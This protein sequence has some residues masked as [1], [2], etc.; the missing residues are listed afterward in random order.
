MTTPATTDATSRLMSP[1]PLPTRA[2]A[3]VIIAVFAIVLMALFTYRALQSRE[4]AA[5]RVT[6]T[7]QILEGLQSLHSSL[8][9]AETG[10]RGFLLSNE[11]RYLEP[12]VAARAAV[13]SEFT[14]LRKL[15]FDSGAEQLQRLETLERISTTKLEELDQTI[16]LS[17]AGE[18]A[19]AIAIVRSDRGKNAMDQ[20]RSLIGEMKATEDGLLTARQQEWQ[21]GVTLSS[22]VTWGGS[23]LLLL[24]IAGAVALM[25]RDFRT[26]QI[27]N[28]LRT[29]HMGL[30]ERLQGEQRLEQLGEKVLDFLASYLGAQVGVA[31]FNDAGSFRRF[32]SYATAAEENPPAVLP[33]DGLL[34]QA[35][36]ERRVLHVTNVPEGYLTVTSQLGRATPTEILDRAGD[37]RSRR[38][39]SAGARILPP[40]VCCRPRAPRTRVRIAWCGRSLVARPDPA[41]G[42]ARRD[43]APGRGTADAAGGAPRQQRRA[44]GAEPRAARIPGSAGNA[45]GRARADQLA[46]RGA[47]AEARG[48]EERPRRGAGDPHRQ[49]RGAR[50]RESVQERVPGQHEP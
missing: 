4:V 34:G 47:D 29:G 5:K 11:E 40:S 15:M 21:D 16:Q 37:S 19:M 13:P 30:A 36:R 49:G 27:Q 38:L 2:I 18:E 1:M 28:W 31:Y 22:R 44:R 48:P 45:A 26:L 3:G 8:K 17:R 50:A 20:V 32:A 7:L 42:I 6:Q 41:R 35:A 23:I 9:D 43:A 33:G 12:Y 10:Q 46:P 25:S 14:T 24:L 39:R